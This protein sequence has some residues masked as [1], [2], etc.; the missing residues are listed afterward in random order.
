MASKAE[1]VLRAA[2][3]LGLL[4][5][6][7]AL[8]SQD[9]TRISSGYDEVYEDLKDEGLA[10]WASDAEVPTKLVPHVIAL[11]A[12]NC[13]E[14]YSISEARYKRIVFKTGTDGELSRKAIRKLIT[15]EYESLTEP[16]DF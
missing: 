15:P 4:R 8:Q 3:D 2:S 1:T 16:T 12:L 5:L 6:G 11:V 13:T 9:D 7:Q 10:I 14:T